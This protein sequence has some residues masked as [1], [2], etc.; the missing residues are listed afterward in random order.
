[1]RLDRPFT[2]RGRTQR[3]GHRRNLRAFQ[4]VLILALLV[5]G[6]G[7]AVRAAGSDTPV[8]DAAQA[9]DVAAVRSRLKAGRARSATISR[10]SS[11]A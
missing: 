7:V 8:A 9:R 11:P 2:V 1:M 4:G 5:S 10:C 6:I 3:L